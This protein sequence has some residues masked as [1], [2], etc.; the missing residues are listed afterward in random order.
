MSFGDLNRYVMRV[1][2]TSDP[3]QAMV[4]KHSYE[5]DHHWPWYLE[6][7]IKLRFEREKIWT[8]EYLRLFSPCSQPE[9]GDFVP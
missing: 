3:Y 5:D 4:N 1:E 7:L 8:T 6:D 2:P 9:I